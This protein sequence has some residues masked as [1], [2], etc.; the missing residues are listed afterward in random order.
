[1]SINHYDA[2]DEMRTRFYD[3]WIDG[4]ANGLPL[5]DPP[6]STPV[7]KRSNGDVY[8]PEAVW[9]N[10]ERI[11]PNDNGVHWI[12]FSAV[13]F[14]FTQ[15]GFRGIGN[16][17]PY[18]GEGIVT[19]QIFLSKSAYETVD[20]KALGLIAQSAFVTKSTDTCVWYRSPTINPLPPEENHFRVNVTAEYSYDSVLT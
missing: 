13:E 1:M 14:Q 16:G 17:V 19:V 8:T 5:L 4:L 20:E 18:T 3:A 9:Q 12:R 15:S 11:D 2:H 10:V 7:F 6:L